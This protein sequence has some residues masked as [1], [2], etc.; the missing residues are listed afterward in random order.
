MSK[1]INKVNEQKLKFFLEKVKNGVDI[2]PSSTKD[3]GNSKRT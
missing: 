1:G 3:K 2:K